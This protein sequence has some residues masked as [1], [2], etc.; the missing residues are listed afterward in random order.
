MTIENFRKTI[1]NTKWQKHYRMLTKNK[2]KN[3]S[4]K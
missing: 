1:A 2:F 4:L 3:E